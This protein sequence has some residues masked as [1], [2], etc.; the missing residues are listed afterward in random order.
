MLCDKWHVTCGD[1]WGWSFS[2]NFSSLTLT[3]W[4]RQ[5]LFEDLEK[6]D[7]WLSEI[8]L[9]VLVEQ[10]RLYRVKP[11]L[12]L[13]TLNLNLLTNSNW[14]KTCFCCQSGNIKSSPIPLCHG[15]DLLS[16]RYIWD[17]CHAQFHILSIARCPLP[18]MI[19]ITESAGFFYHFPK[20][21]P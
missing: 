17:W 21:R 3:V 13:G 10:P 1:W 19:M 14:W 18:G 20:R 11:G 4:E 12:T 5:F 9:M 15:L 7:D 8:I 16:S 2:Q 6:K